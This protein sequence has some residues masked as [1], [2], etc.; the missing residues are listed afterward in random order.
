MKTLNRPPNFRVPETVTLSDLAGLLRLFLPVSGCERN[1]TTNL[2]RVALYSTRKTLTDD[3]FVKQQMALY[4]KTLSLFSL[5]STTIL[6]NQSGYS[7][8]HCKSLRHANIWQ[9]KSPTEIIAE[10][11]WVEKRENG[12][13]F[14][15]F[16]YLFFYICETG[17]FFVGFQLYCNWAVFSFRHKTEPVELC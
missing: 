3:S 14:H 12:L 9:E 13:R 11:S 8:L 1:M 17:C 16:L 2:G 6:T 15:N 5:T 7:I 10:K 4:W